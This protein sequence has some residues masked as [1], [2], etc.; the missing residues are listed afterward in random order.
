MR[1]SK[2]A[3]F[4]GNAN[5]SA[6]KARTA[7]QAQSFTAHRKS[8]VV[9]AVQA[10]P[11]SKRLGLINLHLY[12][13]IFFMTRPSGHFTT[14]ADRR[15]YEISAY[16]EMPPFFMTVVSSC[17]L[18]LFLSST[19]GITAGRGAPEKAIFPYI[20]ADQLHR[21]ALHTGARTHIRVARDGRIHE[22]EP[23][24]PEQQSDFR[25]E[26]SLLKDELGTEVIF[27]ER[28]LSLGLSFCYS[29][30]CA[31][32]F[33]I[34]RN[35]S[36]EAFDSPAQVELIDGLLN[37]LP[38]E[39]PRSLQ[40]TSSN[41]VDA[42]KWNELDPGSRLCSY[43]LYARISDRADP[44]ESLTATVAY[45]LGLDEAKVC[46][47][48]SDF[49]AL[50]KCR[51]IAPGPVRR[52]APGAYLLHASLM[53]APGER[54]QWSIVLD[55]D[56]S[57]SAVVERRLSLASPDQTRDELAKALAQEHARLRE[58]LV[59]ADAF[60]AV[61]VEE[62]ATHHIANT[63]FNVMRGG[64]FA[65]QYLIERS[66]YA[67]NLRLRNPGIAKRYADWLGQLP[68]KLSLS[69]LSQRAAR[70]GDA[71]LNR[72]TREY[73]PLVFG[74]RHG[75]P[76]R[77]WNHFSIRGRDAQGRLM[78]AYQGN[79]RDIFQNWEALL[80]SFPEFAP[81]I[82]A[83][84][85]NASTLDGY[86]PYRVDH[87]GIDWEV[88]DP[89]DPWSHIGYWGD[90]QLV[91]LLRLLEF[92][93]R[94][95][96]AQLHGMLQRSEFCYA[97]V[98]YRIAGFAQ[99]LADPKHTVSFDHALARAIEA[100]LPTQGSDAKL[101]ADASAQVLQVT[102][103]EKLVV[104]LLAKLGNLVPGGGIWLCTQRPEW[105]DANNALVGSGL[106]MVTLYHARRY[107]RFLLDLIAGDGST[108]AI[109]AN[110]AQW[111][112]ATTAALEQAG[113]ASV[114]DEGERWRVFAALGEA[115]D[116][117]R[118][119]AYS[120]EELGRREAIPATEIAH[121]LEVCLVELDRSIAY[122]RR[123]DGLFHAYNLMQAGK[124]R[125]AVETLYPMLEGQ[126]AALS[127]GVLG[128]AEA[129]QL[130][131]ALFAS[132]MYRPDQHSFMLYPNPPLQGFLEKNHVPA[133]ALQEIAVLNEMLARADKRI[134]D[135][136]AQGTL[137][138]TPR[139]INAEEL[140]H[141]LEACRPDYPA[142]DAKSCAAI[143]ALYEEVQSPP[144]HGPVGNHVLFRRTG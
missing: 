85:V 144:L 21:S 97:N 49:D 38:S 52:G 122:N 112:R 25:L 119:R 14:I 23:F 118:T 17:D 13:R 129:V 74:R 113:P 20:S 120:G 67:A 105:N 65:D 82:V 126:V 19:G 34:V 16:D 1:L 46:I 115:S 63:L 81:N 40:N 6:A 121:F 8:G 51:A 7:E 93:Q 102:L 39:T 42:Y 86:N 117:Y 98:P 130:L 44:A 73:L 75:D 59:E 47:A 56:L 136:D 62:N 45:A 78:C 61:Q 103:I 4:R 89:E 31:D 138:F 110:V 132:D 71:H 127:S 100:R 124:N 107:T 134:I 50:R 36:L 72:L 11:A 53:L 33:G 137:R 90:H 12:P 135:R 41:L 29:W 70:Q 111:L 76:S 131:E 55:T 69:E 3:Q 141:A 140:A 91:Y 2:D 109:S 9:E 15:Y 54:R 123:A 139:H 94:S 96:P 28:N 64:I 60:Q 104:P 99:M 95:A 88:E 57:Q 128:A 22:W 101:I 116:L 84:F 5:R 27:R 92:C 87:T 37:I 114:E 30:S 26:R 83:K 106:S 80:I 108:C 133:R 79:W 24:N 32:A 142:L 68:D 48:A 18:W 66:D 10:E 58:L 77:P 125:L 43:S 143:L 35:A